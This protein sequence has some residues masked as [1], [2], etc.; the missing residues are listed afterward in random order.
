MLFQAL[1]RMLDPEI[2]QTSC[3]LLSIYNFKI[4]KTKLSAI[5]LC[6][7][8][9]TETFLRVFILKKLMTLGNILIFGQYYF[10]NYNIY[11]SLQLFHELVLGT[12]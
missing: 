1:Y 12:C 10:V 6:N 11:L 8:L 2:N 4:N 3:D 7:H 5:Y 9:I